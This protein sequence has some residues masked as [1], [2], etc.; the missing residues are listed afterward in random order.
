MIIIRIKIKKII[1]NKNT[2]IRYNKI[3]FNNLFNYNNNN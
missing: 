3:I 2:L 1:N